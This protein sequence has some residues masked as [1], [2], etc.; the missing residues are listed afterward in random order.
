M[1]Y[2]TLDEEVSEVNINLLCAGIGVFSVIVMA[3]TS[4]PADQQDPADGA[5]TGKSSWVGLL[6]ASGC[7]SGSGAPSMDAR[8][9]LTGPPPNGSSG[10]G[11]NGTSNDI[12]GSAATRVSQSPA[13]AKNVPTDENFP[14][15]TTSAAS[16]SSGSMNTAVPDSQTDAAAAGVRAGHLDPACRIG[17]ATTTFNL[18]LPGG[19]MIPFDSASNS[20]IADQVHGRTSGHGKKIFRAEVKG[21]MRGDVIS[22]DSIRL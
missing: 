4:Q 11:M 9:A 16:E 15:S 3:Q 10:S 20:R 8:S 2:L 5:K 12:T 14:K 22:V 21:T 19:K 6:V 13:G 18:L 7:P 17:P 1:H